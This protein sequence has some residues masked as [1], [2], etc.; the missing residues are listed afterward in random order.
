MTIVV[1]TP[2]SQRVDRVLGD[3][4]SLQ[5]DNTTGA[6]QRA[7][8]WVAHVLQDANSR[9]RWWFLERVATTMLASG[10]DVVELRGHIDKPASVFCGVRLEK[11]SLA[12]ITELR[13]AA[14]A[15]GRAN[16]GKPRL[17]AIERT[18]TGLRF[19]L[20]PAPPAS[21]SQAFTADAGTEQLA[22]ASTTSL[23]TGSRVRASNTGG[24]LPAPLAAGTTYYVINVD[25]THV[26]LATSLALAKAGTA[27]DLTDA[28][29]GTHA[30]L[31]GLTPFACLYTRPMDLAIVPDFWE[32]V[33]LDGVLGT[34]G[35]HFDRDALG[36][37]PEEFERRYESKLQR[38]NTDSWD[39]E[40][41]PLYEDSQDVQD[42]FRET[43]DAASFQTAQSESGLATSYTVPASLTGIGYVTIETGDYPLVVS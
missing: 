10:E 4:C 8:R 19:H 15:L 42:L 38:A 21:S 35:R 25:A 32:T 26:N 12:R 37:S 9:C 43:R 34:Y 16:A 33:V 24:A 22:L 29:S 36:S 11:T 13:Q 1:T 3:I 31:Y 28:G 20:W 23:P 39:L 17:Y 2:I 18:N 40:R 27:I 14:T 7:L 6:R 41:A 5:H 30:L